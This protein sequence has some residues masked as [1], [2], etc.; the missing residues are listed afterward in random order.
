MERSR[1][2]GADY[3]D[4]PGAKHV[5][6]DK[7]SLMCILDCVV[8]KNGSNAEQCKNNCFPKFRK[9]SQKTTGKSK[10]NIS[11]KARS[12]NSHRSRSQDYK[13]KNAGKSQHE[14]F[15]T[16]TFHL[17]DPENTTKEKQEH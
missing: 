6:L 7:T 14:H 3:S 17:K 10:P 9:L 4:S 12:R 13:N 5:A 8:S 1:E 15:E 11:P 16:M 2:V